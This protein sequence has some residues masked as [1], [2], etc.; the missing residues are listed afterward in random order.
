MRTE[1]TRLGATYFV[2]I[3]GISAACGSAGGIKANDDGG[4]TDATAHTRASSDGRSSSA[5]DAPR[6]VND[7]A[8]PKVDAPQDGS[9]ATDSDTA[10]GAP[11]DLGTA[12]QFVILTKTGISTVSPSTIT[13]DLGISPAAATYITGFSLVAESTN[14]FSTSSQI[15]GRVYAADYA[16]P[17][18]QNLTTAIGDM[19][20]AF[21]AAARRAPGVTGLGAGSIGGMTLPPGV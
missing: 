12:G 19:E 5:T 3:L 7:G 18:P 16:S 14:V 17:T 10:V 4:L 21:T 15:T 9:R 20:T 1:A 8:S 2:L 6:T 13:G 11:V